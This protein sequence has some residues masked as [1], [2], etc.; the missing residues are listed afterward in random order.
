[1]IEYMTLVEGETGLID[2]KV[3]PDIVMALISYHH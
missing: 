2:S 1:M 3:S